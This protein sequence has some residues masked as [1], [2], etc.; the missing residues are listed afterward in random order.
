MADTKT[1]TRTGTH[2]QTRTQTRKRARRASASP[3]LDATL[4]P[5]LFR[6]LADPGRTAILARLAQARCP[7]NVGQIAACCPTDI[8]VVSRHLAVLRDAGVLEAE[9]RGREV[10]Y[11]VRCSELAHLLHQL[12]DALEACCPEPAAAGTGG[13]R[14]RGSRG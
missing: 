12:A 7:L 5:R 8:S 9:K 13:T 3:G 6:A 1:H 4:S 11:R 2:R 10:R 14:S